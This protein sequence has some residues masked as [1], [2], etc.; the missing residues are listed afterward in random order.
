VR[1]RSNAPKE[2]EELTSLLED[3]AGCKGEESPEPVYMIPRDELE[4]VPVATV[5]V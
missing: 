5:H 1:A 4:S 3:G 2:I